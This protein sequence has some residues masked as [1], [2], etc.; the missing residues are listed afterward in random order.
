MWD[1]FSERAKRSVFF[2]QEETARLHDNEVSTGHLLLGLMREECSAWSVL[3]RL[4]I[5]LEVVKDGVAAVLQP[6]GPNPIKE[7]MLSPSAKACIDRA[8]DEARALDEGYIGTE[9]LL[10][11]IISEEVGAGRVLVGMGADLDKARAIV[12]ELHSRAAE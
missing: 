4:G 3:D 2:A 10:M 7:M 5:S 12:R 11:G 1:R 9:H 8:Y 6:G